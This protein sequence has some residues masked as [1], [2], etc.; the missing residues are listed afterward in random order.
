MSAPT[1]MRES[2]ICSPAS[3]AIRCC[4]VTPVAARHKIAVDGDPVVEA[5]AGI[6]DLFDGDPADVACAGL[7][8]QFAQ[9]LSGRAA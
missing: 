9:A 6:G 5:H 3:L 2:R 7:D 1:T 4:G 8:D